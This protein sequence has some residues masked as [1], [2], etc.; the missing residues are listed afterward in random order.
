MQN[1]S[2]SNDSTPALSRHFIT[3]RP[4]GEV[5]R[6]IE[7][8]LDL[9]QLTARARE[10]IGACE[11]RIDLAGA[12]LSITAQASFRTEVRASARHGEN[13]LYGKMLNV[14]RGIGRLREQRRARVVSRHTRRPPVL[15]Y[16]EQLARLGLRGDGIDTFQG[17]VDAI[18]ISGVAI[19]TAKARR[20][21]C[22]CRYR[23]RESLARTMVDIILLTR[24]RAP[25]CCDRDLYAS[26][27]GFRL[28]L[29]DSQ[30][31][32]HRA[33][34]LAAHEGCEYLGRLHVT[35]GV[36]HSPERCASVHWAIRGVSGPVVFTRIGQHGTNAHS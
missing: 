5:V 8:A 35:L 2:P 16:A 29:S 15:G 33:D 34:Y 36:G 18:A 9:A 13:G 4:I 27:R 25:G 32:E 31:T 21:A 10:N 1:T 30:L 3:H 24:K 14:V 28:N 7:T 22:D 19:V 20:G 23:D 26:L 11:V 17:F 12:S 6:S